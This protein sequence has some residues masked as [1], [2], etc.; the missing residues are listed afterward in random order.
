MPRLQYRVEFG[1]TTTRFSTQLIE[2]E[3]AL[4]QQCNPGRDDNGGAVDGEF[5]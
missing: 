2:T 4:E 1:V 3:M 5:C